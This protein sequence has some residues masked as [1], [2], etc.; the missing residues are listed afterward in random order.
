MSPSERDRAPSSGLEG[1]AALLLDARGH[2]TWWSRAA[3]DLLGRTA[4]DIGGRPAHEVLGTPVPEP[5][6]G[7]AATVHRVRLRPGT[8]GYADADLALLPGA[9]DGVR[10]LVLRGTAPARDRAGDRHQRRG[11]DRDEAQ[12]RAL[13]RSLFGQPRLGVAEFDPELRMTRSN[14]AL[15][16]LRPA[17]AG[18]DWLYDLTDADGDR[19]VRDILRHVASTG[20]P[21]VGADFRAGAAGSE[22]VLSLACFP[23]DDADG[24]RRGV[25]V[26]TTEPAAR[27]RAQHRLTDAYRRAFEIGESL[28][29]VRAAR[30]LADLLVPALG[31]LACVDFPDDVLQ[32]RDPGLGYPGHEASN[33]RRVAVRS[34]DG[35]WPAALVQQGEPV[36]AVS[37]AAVDAAV[38]VGGVMKVDAEAALA[39]LGDDPLLIARMMPEGMH[40]ALGCPLYH[41]SRLF[42]YVLVW[43]TRNPE[44]FGDA[45]TRLLQDLCDRTAMA[46][47]NAHRYTREHRT[48]LVLQRSLL[49]PA[50]TESQA[51]ET[52]GIYLPASGTLSVGGD[53]FDALPLSS[54]RIGLVVGDVIGHGLQAT[55]TMARLRTAVQTLAD[56]ELPPDE[57][58]IHLDDLVQRMQAESEQPD[59]VGA[60]CLFAVYDPVTR[61]C[62]MASAGHPAPAVLLPDGSA[63]FV[64]VVPGP[65]LGVGDNPFE[66]SEVTLEPGSVLALYTDGLVDYDHDITRGGEE[67][68]RNLRR[69]HG[70]DRSLEAMG[71]D[72]M[73]RHPH[74][75]RPA[76]DVTLLLAR[77]R[78]VSDED[79]A[80]WEYPVDP[81]AVHDA[82]HD[83]NARLAAWGLDEL[84]FS[85][86]LIVSEL[87]TNAIRYA[88]G[89]VGLRLIRGR[90]L[91]CEV[92]D[93]SNT[94]PRLRRA[95]ITDEGGRGLFLIAQLASRWGCR[96]GERGKTIWAEQQVP[97]H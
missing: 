79:T 60:S 54:M 86:E 73:A 46:L 69:L 49:P 12:D 51:A 63:D 28:D 68:L 50:V 87:V 65:P 4:R 1:L 23:V 80:H 71:A 27:L 82:R 10:L 84:M 22:P 66:I 48:A 19:T 5:S 2:V 53:W 11:G 75:E 3:E 9:A 18:A 40:S 91:V 88:G 14:A 34:A 21:V 96:Y 72:L 59:A 7:S 35:V 42:G 44:P 13:A 43:R 30:D 56:L 70:S 92:S 78:A 95:L 76:D 55:A 97:P 17:G 15:D 36:P 31:D 67:L 26:V 20:T 62:R 74:Q 45:D 64:P 81:A 16:A 85:T 24:V 37:A 25:A 77:T 6:P 89:P 58:L 93:P 90:S 57:L 32:G 41:R 47:D 83:V 52:S 8:D 94:Q 29:V 38:T 33:P 39:M 61:V